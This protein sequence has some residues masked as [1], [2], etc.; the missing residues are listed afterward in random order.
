MNTDAE[1]LKK[2]FIELARRADSRDGLIYSGFLSLN[3]QS[4]LSGLERTLPV[5]V[6]FFGGA[7]GCERCVAR[8]GVSEEEGFDDYPIEII[9]IA[10]K[11]EK[12]AGDLS[13][14]DFLGALMH[15]GI[16]REK[17][18]DIIL[19]GKRAYAFVETS[20]APYFADTLETVGRT[21]VVCRA[22]V[23]L[24]AGELYRTEDAAVRIT[25]L[26][27]DALTAQVFRLSRSEAAEL[28]S[29]ERVFINGA[30][31]KGPA[32]SPKEGDIISA[33]GLGRFIFAGISGQSK[34]G[35]LIADIKKYV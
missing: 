2:R 3:E 5:P 28:F 30:L 12:F 10:P 6:A 24:P 34:K 19:R 29:S 21:S 14:R 22:G 17:I 1:A 33:R 23:D 31:A 32:A 8:F 15:T 7:Q 20:L 4:V 9:E 11:N 27:L 13:H 25:S 18:G 35:K 26:R 16:E